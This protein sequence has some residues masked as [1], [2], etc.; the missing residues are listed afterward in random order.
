MSVSPKPL[1]NSLKMLKEPEQLELFTSSS[2]TAI[3]DQL[4]REIVDVVC[5]TYHVGTTHSLRDAVYHQCSVEFSSASH[6][7]T[8][9]GE[10]ITGMATALNQFPASPLP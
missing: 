4:C 9:I 7:G 6:V 2:A 1:P 5:Q 3:G 10:Y 8:T